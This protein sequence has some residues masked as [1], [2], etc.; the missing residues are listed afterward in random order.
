M[1]SPGVSFEELLNLAHQNNCVGVEVRNDLAT[2]L[3]SGMSAAEAG[4][5]AKAKGIKILGLAQL[6]DFNRLTPARKNQAQQLIQLAVECSADAVCLIP[7]N[8]GKDCEKVPRKANL[9][10]ALEE[11]AP[12][13]RA[14]G[15]KG[16][17]EPLGFIT[18]SLRFKAEVVEEINR[19]DLND[20]YALVHDTFHHHL[21][22]GGP[23]FPSHTGIIHVSGV[24]DKTVSIANMVDA[25]RG[26][27]DCDDVLD[28]AGQLR[29]LVAGGFTGPVSM[30]AFAPAVHRLP[31]LA[32]Q[33]RHSF[34]FINSGLT[35][36]A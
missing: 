13:L 30:E 5:L 28:N 17:I 1:T 32:E 15:V 23:V 8:D 4:S 16:Y 20:C 11:L 25:H 6:N 7:R 2:P 34:N 10:V 33:L 19:L 36:V 27:V 29:A 9:C 22:G 3:F 14:A 24:T 26:L 18:S 12:L 21:A 35:A 31:D